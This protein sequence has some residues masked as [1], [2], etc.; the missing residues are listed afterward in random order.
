MA[1]A[2]DIAE[3]EPKRPPLDKLGNVLLVVTC[4]GVVLVVVAVIWFMET[5][6]AH[7][8]VGPWESVTVEV[9]EGSFTVSHRHT[10][11]FLAEF[12][13]QLEFPNGKSVKLSPN[14]GGKPFLN[15][16]EIEHEGGHYVL[17]LD[18]IGAY[19][20]TLDGEVVTTKRWAGKFEAPPSNP[21]TKFIG[22]IEG[23]SGELTFVPVSAEREFAIPYAL[24][25]WGRDLPSADENATLPA[26]SGG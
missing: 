9:S 19:R 12:D 26:N 11:P 7:D 5:P 4:V 23:Y 24:D 13:R 1:E 20:L 10:H 21:P 2:R 18:R 17:I 8:E 16:Y 14:T 25:P 6:F 3:L 22:R 15:I